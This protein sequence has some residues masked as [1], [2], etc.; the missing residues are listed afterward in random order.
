MADGIRDKVVIIGMGCTKCTDRVFI[1][2]KGT[3]RTNGNPGGNVAV[4]RVARSNRN[5]V[6]VCTVYLFGMDAFQPRVPRA[7]AVQ[8]DGS[9]HTYD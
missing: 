7:T 9:A 4:P 8:F 3:S 1:A 6:L 2:R 5:T